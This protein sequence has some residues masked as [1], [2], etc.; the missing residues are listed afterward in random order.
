MKYFFRVAV[1]GLFVLFFQQNAFCATKIGILDMQKLQKESKN[2]KKVAKR[3]E[4]KFESLKK[5]IKKEQDILRKAEEEWGKQSS[6][7][8]AEARETKRREL[9]KKRMN[10]KHV[11]EDYASQLRSAE[12]EVQKEVGKDLD[13]IVKDIGDKR[14]YTLILEKR[15]IGLVYYTD[16]LDIT[17]EVIKAYDALKR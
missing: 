4:Q 17:D 3:F 15:T 14:G 11:A 5:K 2:F 1:V 8:S 10:Y 13:K 6:I 12:L 9:E 16:G 7:L